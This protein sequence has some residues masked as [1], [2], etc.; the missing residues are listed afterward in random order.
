M[1]TVTLIL[2][3]IG[4]PVLAAPVAVHAQ[5][6]AA[7]LVSVERNTSGATAGVDVLAGGRLV[8]TNTSFRDL[9]RFVH[10]LPETAVEGGPVWLSTDRYDL[11]VEAEGQPSREQWMATMRTLLAERL[12]LVTRMETRDGQAYELTLLDTDGQLGPNLAL[13][14][15]SCTVGTQDAP[16]PSC[17]FDLAPGSITA[18]GRPMERLVRAIGQVCGAPVEDRTHLTG[19]YDLRV[20]WTPDAS[21]TPC[22]AL[23]TAIERQLGLTLRRVDGAQV[24][25][26]ESAVRP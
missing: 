17:R 10:G 9:I 3:A 11:V 12:K 19:L 21:T 7:T 16:S 4:I 2:M 6:A 20:T 15:T 1:P 13:T 23:S 18:V 14:T 24:L 25:V 22:G 8:V 26:I 5:V